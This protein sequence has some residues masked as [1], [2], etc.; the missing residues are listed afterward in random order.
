MR[1]ASI[2]L[3]DDILHISG[4]W[5]HREKFC[6]RGL[7]IPHIIRFLNI[8]QHSEVNFVQGLENVFFSCSVPVRSTWPSFFLQFLVQPS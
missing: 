4:C 7:L 2:A 6:I 5:L 8:V 1:G 3:G